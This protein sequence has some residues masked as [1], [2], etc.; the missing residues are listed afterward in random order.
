MGGHDFPLT[1]FVGLL[2][3]IT[4]VGSGEI[5]SSARLELPNPCIS[6]LAKSL[7]ETS[8]KE[9]NVMMCS[10]VH[11]L[12]VQHTWCTFR[13]TMLRNPVVCD[14]GKSSLYKK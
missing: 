5:M 9:N 7:V 12:L 8:W 1:G 6:Q 10:H 2:A 4:F 3:D 11:C 14:M 13:S